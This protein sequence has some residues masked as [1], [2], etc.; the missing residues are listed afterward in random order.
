MRMKRLLAIVAALAPLH[1]ACGG[2]HLYGGDEDLSRIEVAA[3]YFVPKGR[4]PLPDWRD[5]VGFMAR[6]IEE[7]HL[8]EFDG[9]STAVVHVPD[10]PFFSSLTAEQLREGD[11][12]KLF[13]RTMEEA[14]KRLNWPP[15]KRSGFPVLLV[16][17]D[18]NWRELDDF[19]RLRDVDGVPTHEGARGQEGR[20][21]PGAE[22]GGSRA[23]YVAQRKL[24]YA[25]VSADGWRV[26]YTGSDCVAYHEG[27]GHVLGLPHP[28]PGN[29]SVMSQAQYRYNINETWIDEDQKLKMGWEKP[30]QPVNRDGDLFTKFKA[31]YQPANPRVGE[32]VRVELS[33]PKGAA[34][35]SLVVEVQTE[36]LGPWVRLPQ[37]WQGDAPA[38]ID[39]GSFSAA[40][41]VSYRV[42]A[43]LADGRSEEIRGYFQVR[44]P[45]A[46]SFWYEYKHDPPGKR[47]WSTVGPGLWREVEPRVT[48]L[49]RVAESTEA[50]GRKGVRAIRQ[51]DETL[52]VFIPDARKDGVLMFRFP[53]EAEWKTL[54][55]THEFP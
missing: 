29:G 47:L 49:F 12:T 18:I 22:S 10:S 1:P 6:R 23:A 46:R 54:G 28:E 5:R 3:V 15:E 20:H 40:T 38:S 19:T 44:D 14:G 16:F 48:N 41:P 26:P 51:P 9:Q 24:G 33:W 32:S 36:L 2:V 55:E 30:A 37:S 42:R 45:A 34:V 11:A 53:G 7:F 35:T 52:E 31:L 27:L 50:F 17:S 21:F 39:L 4:T 13:W 8:R 43:T 25:L